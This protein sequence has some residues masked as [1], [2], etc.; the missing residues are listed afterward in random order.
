MKK[1]DQL[2]NI[3]FCG[4]LCVIVMMLGYAALYDNNKEFSL[5]NDTGFYQLDNYLYHIEEKKTAP[6]D[7]QRVYRFTLDDRS[8]TENTL[9]FYIVH[10]YADVYIDDE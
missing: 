1:F 5:R 10:H 6:L 7:V 4:L 8:Y 3:V 2:I 9:A